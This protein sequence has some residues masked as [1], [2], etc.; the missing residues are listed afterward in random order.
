MHRTA[1]QTLSFLFSKI[2]VFE[3]LSD[4]SLGKEWIEPKNVLN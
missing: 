2:L 4:M 3:D 1:V